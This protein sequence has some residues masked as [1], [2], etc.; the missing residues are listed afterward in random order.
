VDT[1]EEISFLDSNFPVDVKRAVAIAKGIIE[2]KVTFRWTFQAST[3]LLCRM[4]DEEVSLLGRSGAYHMGFGTESAA[5][6]ILAL[7]NKPHQKIQDMHE[8][9]RKCK[10]ANIKVTFNLILGYPG[11]TEAHRLKTLQVMGEIARRYP[12]VSFSPNV[13]TPYPGIPV[14]N[15]LKQLGLNGPRSLE[16]WADISLGNNLLPWFQ[17]EE[18]RRAKRMM[19]YFILN[20]QLR[21]MARKSA[22]RI[23]SRLTGA[24]VKPLDWRLKHK[25]FGYP[26]ELWLARTGNWLSL[27]RSLLTGQSLGGDLQK[28]R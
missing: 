22:S 25:F 9:A 16:E 18:Y 7:M 11:E 28:V 24:L 26:L 2:S 4:S 12:N 23:R 17:G 1:L 13:F 15:Q 14:W 20:H 3:D 10:Q 8:T 19:S 27:R 5:E 6:E 21:K